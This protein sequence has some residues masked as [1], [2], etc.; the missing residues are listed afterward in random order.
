M[1]DNNAF[2]KDKVALVTGAA[3]DIG[4][5]LCRKLNTY[6]IK[7]MLTDR[8]GEGL[9]AIEEEL[10]AAGG[11]VRAI[12]GNLEDVDFC[13][14]LPHK[15]VNAF[16]GLDIL[17]NNAGIA[18]KSMIEE[19]EPDVY[20]AIM[21][22]NVRAPFFICRE[23]L[24]YLRVS[25]CGTIINLGSASAHK[26]YEGQSA[27]AISK[28]ALLGLTKS[29]ACE[30]YKD[31][32]QVQIISPGAVYSEMFNL[33]RPDLSAD[34]LI[35]PEDIAS[36]VGFYLERRKASFVIDEVRIHRIGKEPF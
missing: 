14:D 3:G 31:G 6:G 21:N 30:A 25:E 12:R 23:A 26:G 34:E 5:A 32:V 8:N 19:M 1:Q 33:L 35:Q 18:H 20:D 15:T 36:L 17:I 9:Q 4:Q 27:F 10:L 24:A 29:F 11:D 13:M 28:H 16:G 7:I 2:L 22:I